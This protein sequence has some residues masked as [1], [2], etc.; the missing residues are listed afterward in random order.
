[1]KPP[2][3]KRQR[4][5]GLLNHFTLTEEEIKA[6]A[7]FISSITNSYER[8]DE[9]AASL[10]PKIDFHNR[11]GHHPTSRE[12]TFGAWAW[13]CSIRRRLKNPGKL[14]GKKIAVKDN[15]AVAGIPLQNG[16]PLMTGYVPT[17][18]ATVISRILDAGGEITGKSTCEN[19]CISSGSHTSYPLPVKNPRNPDYMAGGSS[20]GSA[21]LLAAGEVDAAI[22]GDQAG[23]IRIPAS[24]CGVFGL[25]PTIGLVPY[26]GVLGM[27]P[28][29][30]HI[31]PMANSVH[32]LAL[33]LEVIAGRD[34]FDPRQLNTPS[35]LPSYS[36]NLSRD[37]TGLKVGLVKEGFGWGNLSEKDVDETAR[38]A[39]FSL[40]ES[41]AIV[42]EL[43]IPEH[44]DA[45]RI[46]S[47]IAMEG[48]R[49]H[50]IRDNGLEHQWAGGFDLGLVEHWSKAIRKSGNKL[51]ESAKL[52]AIV[53]SYIAEEYGGHYYALARN[54]RRRLI[55]IYDDAL[56]KYDVLLMPTVP[57]K[58]P[59]LEGRMTLKRSLEISFN[60]IQNTCGFDASG[61]PALS[62]P[63]GTASGL[64]VGLM[65]IGRYFDEPTLLRLAT[66][67]EKNAGK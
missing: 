47:G 34:G 35:S 54:L 58:A 41:G 16:S 25:K 42:S 3:T 28:T 63:C 50:M 51:S 46:W 2:T 43:S 40:Q 29:I 49:Y 13:K 27:D 45:I 65:I 15:V 23:S 18:D 61:H 66:A 20:S 19:L 1:L 17:V 9:L 14:S 22:G 39:G 7:P 57:K 56:R 30:D 11:R 6:F 37:I 4:S 44:R 36:E 26:S 33:L 67:F 48:M 52:V 24:W 8:L 64:P 31:G 5:L 60:Y 55:E 21:A 32:D 62:V 59:K 38:E 10:E 12:N 53:G